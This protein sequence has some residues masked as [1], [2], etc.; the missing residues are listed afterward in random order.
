MLRSVDQLKHSFCKLVETTVDPSQQQDDPLVAGLVTFCNTNDTF[1]E[2]S[3]II[4]NKV[5]PR[6][7]DSEC[8]SLLIV[9]KYMK[10]YIEW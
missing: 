6:S 1:L 5:R 7:L 4:L 10:K 2:V 3:L 8:C 9:L